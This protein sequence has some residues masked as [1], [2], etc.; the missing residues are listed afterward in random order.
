MDSC[1]NSHHNA[2]YCITVFGVAVPLVL[3][4]IDTI[5]PRQLYAGCCS[6]SLT[7]A[8]PSTPCF[9]QLWAPQIFTNIHEPLRLGDATITASDHVRLLGVTISSDL[10]PVKHV[11]TISLS[12]FYWLHQIR[13]I[14][15][16]LDAE[17]AT[18]LVH[19]FIT[20]RIDGCNTVLAG[21]PR[22]I[23][24]R[25]QRLL[26]ATALVVSILG[27]STKA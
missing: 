4:C 22:T 2:S 25:L 26:N 23:T 17:S 27:S 11:G 14:R 15:R 20:S 16:S 18:T 3:F 5:C 8:A 21:S 24:D 19:V 10:S 6:P 9:Q 13:R 12:C 1:Q 7:P